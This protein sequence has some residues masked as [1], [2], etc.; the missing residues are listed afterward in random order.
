MNM[1]HPERELLNS[2]KEISSFLARGVRTVQ[3]WE[4]IDDLPVHRIGAGPRS[5]VFAFRT[6]LLQWL[7]KGHPTPRQSH[8]LVVAP[9]AQHKVPEICAR[10]SSGTPRR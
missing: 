7:H 4:K 6:E 8:V 3:R 1:V 9:V 2:W 5:P 10:N